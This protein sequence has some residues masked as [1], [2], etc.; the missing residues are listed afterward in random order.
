MSP[1]VYN[2]V[3]SVLLKP[4]A[5]DEKMTRMT[6]QTQSSVRSVRHEL[7]DAAVDLLDENGPDAL[8]TRKVAGAAGTSTMAVYTHFGGMQPLIDA[9]AEEGLRQ[10]PTWLPLAPRTGATRSSGRTCIA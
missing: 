3:I 2:T 6:S 7:L 1:Y 8:Q 4:Y 9:V 10:S 5:V